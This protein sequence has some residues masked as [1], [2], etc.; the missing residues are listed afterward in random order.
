M[1]CVVCTAS[2]DHGIMV[3]AMARDADLHRRDAVCSMGCLHRYVK[4][5]KGKGITLLVLEMDLDYIASNQHGNNAHNGQ[6]KTP[7]LGS[8]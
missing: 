8:P 5:A 6:N 2:M 3:D 7:T 4:D 1:N